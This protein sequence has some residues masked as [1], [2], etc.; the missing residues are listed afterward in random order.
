MKTV[1]RVCWVIVIVTYVTLMLFENS[2]TKPEFSAVSFF[3]VGAGA[4]GGLV[5]LVSLLYHWFR[6]KFNNRL[7]KIFWLVSL[8][9]YPYMIGPI[10]YYLTVFELRKTV[11]KE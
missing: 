5:L 4:I 6:T 7:W 2:L 9:F 1:V 10:A 11:R 8:F 3:V